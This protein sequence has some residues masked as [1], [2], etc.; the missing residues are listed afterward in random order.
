LG[1]EVDELTIFELR[2]IPVEDQSDFFT[3][4]DAPE[5]RL[6][7]HNGTVNKSRSCRY[8]DD[9]MPAGIE[10]WK[11]MVKEMKDLKG[12]TRWEGYLGNG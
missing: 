2:K 1:K 11:R 8:Y 9:K 5:R 7:T 4:D 12:K 3:Q 6:H 10:K